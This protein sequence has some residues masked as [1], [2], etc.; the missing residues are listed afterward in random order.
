MA[1]DLVDLPY[2]VKVKPCYTSVLVTPTG[3]E[4]FCHNTPS[5]WAIPFQGIV[6]AA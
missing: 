6:E 5:P 1:T 3:L 2:S 4:G